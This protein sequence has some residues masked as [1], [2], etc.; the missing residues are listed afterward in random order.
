MQ[1]FHRSCTGEAL[2]NEHT[3]YVPQH[4]KPEF[5][6]AIREMVRGSVR[7]WRAQG[8]DRSG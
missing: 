7:G 2:V 4:Q 8:P 1:A 6:E 3:G 5:F